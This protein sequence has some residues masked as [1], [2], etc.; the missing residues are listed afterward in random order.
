MSFSRAGDYAVK[1]GTSPTVI[2]TIRDVALNWGLNEVSLDLPGTYVK[3]R[4]RLP[5]PVHRRLSVQLALWGPGERSAERLGAVWTADQEVSVEYFGLSLGEYVLTAY[6]ADGKLVSQAPVRFELAPL[7]ERTTVDIEMVPQR[8]RTLLVNDSRGRRVAAASV[9]SF[10]RRAAPRGPGEFDAS[11]MPLG[12]KAMVT[13]PGLIPVCLEAG[14]GD[15]QV[16]VMRPKG[17]SAI[18]IRL[19]GGPRRP[20]GFLLGLPGSV[21]AVPLSTLDVKWQPPMTEQYITLRIEGLPT[22]AYEYR[23]QEWIPG[24]AVSAPGPLVEYQIPSYCRFCGG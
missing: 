14:S 11:L 8:P 1:I 2:S 22:S 13:A 4:I 16:V 24:I 17:G 15:S 19:R 10:G 6:S 21:C 12:Q 23:A 18:D 5:S 3:A 9:Y 7:L 20:V